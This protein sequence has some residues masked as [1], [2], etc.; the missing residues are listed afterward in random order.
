VESPKPSSP[1]PAPAPVVEAPKKIESA[2]DVDH[3]LV[4]VDLT[5]KPTEALNRGKVLSLAIPE[6]ANANQQAPRLGFVLDSAVRQ[7]K[8]FTAVDAVA[9]FDPTGAQERA[10]ATQKAADALALGLKGYRELENGL[11]QE[12]FDRAMG[13]YRDSALWE[14]ENIHGYTEAA[15]M[16]V[17][18][19][20]TD[21]PGATR[22]EITAL[23][24]IDPK[25]EVPKD[26]TPPPPQ[27]LLQ[28]IERQRDALAQTQTTTIDV[29]SRPVPARVYIDGNYKGTTPTSISKVIVGEHLI[30]IISPG[31][32]V[33]QRF[34]RISP[35]DT[36]S[37]TLKL[38][39]KGKQVAELTE[40]IRKSWDKA[41]EAEA[42]KKLAA[43]ADANQ[44]MIALVS[45]HE[46][47]I[48]VKVH[49]V[50]A[51][52]GHGAG[53]TEAQSLPESDRQLP[54]T[55]G[56]LVEK[57]LDVDVPLCNG[58]ACPCRSALPA[59]P[60]GAIVGTGVSAAVLLATGITL[61]VVAKVKSDAFTKVPQTDLLLKQKGNEV[62]SYAIPAD[63]C[64]ALGIV[65]AGVWAY[66]AFGTQYAA[67]REIPGGINDDRPAPN[68]GKS[69]GDDPFESQLENSPPDQKLTFVAAPQP[70]GL[71]LS[72]QG[73]F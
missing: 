3:K 15:L 16:R 22:R 51:S 4:P 59:G 56:E 18:V 30:S 13:A 48:D 9:K 45:R 60:F 55:V 6:E 29:A 49:R 37:E 11:G 5:P 61:A 12:W 43:L 26:L 65:S 57:S 62:L 7:S 41:D 54:R 44:V 31:Y 71:A 10:D 35:G 50:R 17:I 40:R 33:V 47:M 8:R 46:A 32:E 25:I 72:L 24:T 73:A 38:T 34:V 2:G 70:G 68:K 66:L 63:I 42:E 1:E 69:S 67:H 21:D 28:E 36:L 53:C 64:N 20:W 14:K 19:K 23:L 39:E 58:V 27:D 52:D